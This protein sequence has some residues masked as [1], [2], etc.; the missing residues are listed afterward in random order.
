MHAERRPAR[1]HQGRRALPAVAGRAGG[2]PG[3]LRPGLRAVPGGRLLRYD[4]GAP[5]PA[6]GAGASAVA[7][8]ARPASRAGRGL[9]VPERAVPAGHL[10]PGDR[11]ADERQRFE[12]VPRGHAGG[13]LG[14]LRGDGPRADPRG[15]AHARP[16]R[17]LRRP[18]RRRRHGG[19]GRPLRHRLHAA[20]RAGLHRGR[21]H[22]GRPGEARRPRGDQLGELRGRRRPRVAVREGHT[23][24]Q[25][26]RRRADRADHR[27]GGPG[28]H[29]REEGRDRRAADRRPHRQLGHPRGGHP[30][31][32][33]DLHHLHRPGGV[34]Q[35]RHRH[36]R[37]HP[38]AQ[39]APPEG[40]DHAR[41]VEHLLRPQPGRPHPAE[42]RLPGRVR[43][44]RPGLG[45]RARLE[46]P[47]D[48]PVQR[49]GGHHRPR[50]DPRPPPRGL[51][52]AAEAHA[53]V[54]GRHR[55]VAEGR[56]GRGTGRPAAGGAPQAPHHRRRAQR[57]GGG[58]GRG[59]PRAARARHR[60]RHPAGRHEGR[61][62]AVRIRPDA[63]AVRAP[64]RRG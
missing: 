19:T 57:P 1:A 48:R 44:G 54:R 58:P 24:G 2:R 51:R 22:P 59:P 60:Q 15:R 31:R 13:P 46:D 61:R 42:L 47:A 36:H 23:A 4:A 3:G 17:G 28:P 32:L 18:R 50:P 56:Q 25:G 55:Q 26:A 16:V 33:P 34:P 38:R 52:P 12:E 8:R 49:G 11:R 40:A 35:G 43:Q 45:D 21:R 39:A 64:V 10:L 29:R 20:D 9:P 41:P 53:A 27:R 7:G 14:Q 63:A 5:A 6:R 62:G 37:G 30:R